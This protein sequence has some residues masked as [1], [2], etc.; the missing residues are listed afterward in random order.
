MAGQ[1]DIAEIRRRLAAL[2]GTPGGETF[3]A[4]VRSVDE[5]RRTCTVEAGGI[6]YDDVRLHAVAD[7]GRKG[8][9]FIPTV[10]SVVLVSRIGGSNELFAAMFSEVDAALL[11]IGEKTTVRAEADGLTLAAGDTA[12]E[13]TAD[14][15]KLTRGSA[16]LL[17]TLSDLCDALAR[18]TVPT[19]VGPS[20]VPVNAADFTAIKNE[21]KQ[22]LKG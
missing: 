16:G 18:L 13:A 6:G 17:K 8:F 20:G 5:T 15:L 3:P 10:G 19:A 7:A 11:T 12:L 9:C 21:L 22:Y 14:G 2:G 4:T 1:K